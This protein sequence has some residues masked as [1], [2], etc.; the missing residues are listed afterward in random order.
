MRFSL[1]HPDTPYVQFMN[2]RKHSLDVARCYVTALL[3]IRIGAEKA[4]G[5]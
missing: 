2:E 4:H 5:I 1:F 3:Q